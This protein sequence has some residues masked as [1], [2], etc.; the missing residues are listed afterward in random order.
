MNQHL[1]LRISR[2][3]IDL[4]A[5]ELIHTQIKEK[6][7][8]CRKEKLSEELVYFKELPIRKWNAPTILS[9]TC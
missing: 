8:S 7:N 1:L 9:S 6:R 3:F 2:N 4:K 5:F